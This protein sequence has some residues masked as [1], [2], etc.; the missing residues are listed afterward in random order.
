MALPMFYEAGRNFAFAVL[1]GHDNDAGVFE[2]ESAFEW[3]YEFHH[4]SSP[5]PFGDDDEDWPESAWNVLLHVINNDR[6]ARKQFAEGYRD[7]MR[8]T[9]QDRRASDHVA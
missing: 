3:W 6:K 2:P 9:R 1:A 8:E 5:N 7:A 4:G